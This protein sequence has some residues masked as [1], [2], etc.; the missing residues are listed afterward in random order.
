MEV[1]SL[2]NRRKYGRGNAKPKDVNGQLTI[3]TNYY[4]KKLK[5]IIKGIFDLNTPIYWDRDYILNTLINRGY[6]GISQSPAGVLPFIA[7]PNGYNYAGTPVAVN[8]AA[9]IIGD[10]TANLSTIGIPENKEYLVAK[11]AKTQYIATLVYLERFGSG[12]YFNFDET[13]RIYAEKLASADCSIDVNL[14][15]SRVGYIVEAESRG[16]ADTLKNIIDKIISGEPVVVSRTEKINPSGGLKAFFGNVKQ[17]YI[18]NDIQDTKKE[19]MYEFLTE[20]GINSANTDKKERLIVDE[21][22]S[23][24]QELFT[25][26]AVWRNNL[27]ICTERVRSMFPGLEFSISLKTFDQ[28]NVERIANDMVRSDSGMGNQ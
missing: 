20:I 12:V 14:M 10:F 23:N 7:E 5:R 15:T 22:N 26:T 16:Q 4:R 17:A 21:V 28:S 9:P 8:I 25:S 24:N 18:A 19:I 3:R 1:L 13:V 6:F 27:K 2:S 11:D